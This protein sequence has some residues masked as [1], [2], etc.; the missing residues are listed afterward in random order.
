MN[1][2]L[3]KRVLICGLGSI[4]RRYCRLITKKWPSINLAAVRSGNGG[5]VEEESK[6]YKCFDSISAALK[7]QP[8]AAIIAS[9]ASLH[10]EQSCQL[11]EHSIPLLIEKPVGTGYEDKALYKQ[12]RYLS[13]KTPIYVGY[14]LRHDPCTAYMREQLANGKLGKLMSADFFCGSWLPDWRPGQNYKRSV[15]AQR[16]L[17]GGA[18]LELSHELDMAQWLLGPLKL[19][20]TIIRNSGVL[21]I[22]VEDQAYLLAQD[23]DESPVT[24][25]LDFS[26]NPPKRTITLRFTQGELTWDVINGTITSSSNNNSEKKTNLGTT[27][28]ERFYRQLELFWQHPQS[29]QTEI[30]SLEEGFSAL[31]LAIKAR[32]LAEKHKESH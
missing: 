15:S 14:V 11:G 30:C 9:P 8:N 17:G 16:E 24:I 25:R 32:R 5:A 3:P 13:S 29:K 7:W 2:Q 6:L 28:D 20:S 19:V 22:E 1:H 23:S 31:E 26:T 4:G 10:I 18:L 21:D 12:L 27:S